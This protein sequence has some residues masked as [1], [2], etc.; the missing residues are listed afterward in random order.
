MFCHGNRR[1]TETLTR[2]LILCYKYFMNVKNRNRQQIQWAIKLITKKDM[3][4]MGFKHKSKK[5][6]FE[7]TFK[8]IL[9]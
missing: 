2:T 7:E 6:S 4:K 3:G 1:V 5:Q 8:V 9:Q